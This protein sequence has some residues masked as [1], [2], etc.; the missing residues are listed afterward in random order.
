MSKVHGEHGL[1]EQG[2]GAGPGGQTM[3]AR[4][5]KLRRALERLARAEEVRDA[6]HQAAS[7]DFAADDHG[8]TIS[9]RTAGRGTMAGHSVPE[10]QFDENQAI[11]D[12]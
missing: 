2:E 1:E 9:S 10:G 8:R 12:S 11:A 5:E 3:A 6:G 7:L 4:R